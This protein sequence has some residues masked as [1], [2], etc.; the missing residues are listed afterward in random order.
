MLPKQPD[1]PAS[2][3]SEL[4][5]TDFHA[6]TLRAAEC[7]RMRSS[8]RPS[9]QGSPSICFRRTVPIRSMKSSTGTSIPASHEFR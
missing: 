5:R 6:W 9:K 7:I 1:Q 2:A 4:Y 3:L 8:V